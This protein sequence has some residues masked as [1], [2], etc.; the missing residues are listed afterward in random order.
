MANSTLT[1]GWMRTS[2]AIPARNLLQEFW[3]EPILLAKRPDRTGPILL[4]DKQWDIVDS[5]DENDETYV[6][7]ANMVGKDFV[8]GFIALSTFL[9]YD[10]VRVLTTSVKD[11]HLRVLWGEIYRWIDTCLVPLRYEQGGPLI[12]KHRDIRKVRNG[13]EDSISYLL[14]QVSEKGEGM[15]GHHARHTL[16]VGDEASGLDDLCYTQAATWAKRMLIFGNCNTCDNFFRRG[17][18][19]GDL[20]R[21]VTPT[22]KLR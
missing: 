11:D 20:P 8:A 4:Y 14:G 9:R 1:P 18:E 13:R 22:R 21:P 16:F 6:P 10:E 12:I 3:N 7:A 2:A 15:A 19:A 5:V 17:V